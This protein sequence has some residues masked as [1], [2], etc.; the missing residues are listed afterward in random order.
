MKQGVGMWG[1]HYS[2]ASKFH[3][4]FERVKKKR[5]KETLI[6]FVLFIP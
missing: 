5:K 4:Q 1:S 6:G 2:L 3:M